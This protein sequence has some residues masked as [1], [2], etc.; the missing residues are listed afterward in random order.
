MFQEAS[1]LAGRRCCHFLWRSCTYDLSSCRSAFRTYIYNVIG[2]FYNIH[3]VFNN[4]DSISFFYK[5]I[6]YAHKYPYIF[7]MQ[8][9]GRLVED[10]KGF[11]RIA[12]G[13]FGGQFYPLTFATR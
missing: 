4:N 9:G 13:E 3:I 8:A 6:Q 2:C 5:L 10:I 11:A 7:E 12:F 1:G